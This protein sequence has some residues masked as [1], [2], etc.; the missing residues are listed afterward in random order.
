ME[1]AETQGMCSLKNM[2]NAGT[3]FNCCK[4]LHLL[5]ERLCLQHSFLKANR[6]VCLESSGE[7]GMTDPPCFHLPTV[8]H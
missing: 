2:F 6:Q 3:N 7:E 4:C 8:S 5:D 1:K